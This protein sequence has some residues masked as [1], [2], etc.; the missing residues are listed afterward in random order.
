MPETAHIADTAIAMSRI[1]RCISIFIDCSSSMP[2]P[3]SRQLRLSILSSRLG[4]RGA[5][6]M[7]AQVWTNRSRAMHPSVLDYAQDRF[8]RRAF[9]G[10]ECGG[11]FG[12]R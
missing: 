9:I 8:A 10:S 2:W 12:E 11:R 3:W 4:T 1:L 5:G 7:D 6:A